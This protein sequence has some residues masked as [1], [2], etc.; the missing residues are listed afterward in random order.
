MML[1]GGHV[2]FAQLLGMAD[3]L[4]FTLAHTGFSTFKYVPYGPVSEVMPYLIRRAQENS[5]IMP[6]V[7]KE[8][9][10]IAAEIRCR[11]TG[12]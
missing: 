2:H 6:G 9:A 5:S 4:T 10:S 11:L 1:V 8:R 12:V 7:A 3:K